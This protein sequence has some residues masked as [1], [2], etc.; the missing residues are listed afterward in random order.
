MDWIK[1]MRLV[2]GSGDFFVGSWFFD[3]DGGFDFV[4]NYSGDVGG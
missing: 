3:D 4:F 1:G 2:F